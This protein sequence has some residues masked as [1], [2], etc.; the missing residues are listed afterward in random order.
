MQTNL[1]RPQKLFVSPIRYEIPAFQ[2][3]YVWQQEEQWE[4]LWADVIELAQSILEDGDAKPHFLGAVVLQQLPVPTGSIERRIVVDG[5]QR[6]TTLQLLIDAIQEV[7]EVQQFGGPAKRLLA[8]VENT[9]EFRDDNPDHAFKVWPTSVDRVPF[10]HTMSN[11]LSDEDFSTSRVVQ[12]HDFFLGQ[13]EQ[14]LDQFSAENGDRGEAASALERA[15][16]MHLEIVVIDLGESDDPHIIFETMNARGT[17]LLQSDMIKNKIL[18]DAKIELGFDD[19]KRSSKEIQLWP[20]SEDIWWTSEVGRGL[21]RRPRMDVFVNHWLTLRN[22]SETRQ[23]DEFSVFD[24]YANSQVESG[25]NIEAIARDIAS[26]GIS[27]RI[28]KNS[29]ETT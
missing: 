4:P 7:L 10:R 21:Q 15:V 5:Q 1:Q 25:G 16:R 28:S 13:T 26:S 8:L 17:P 2:R 19:T 29:A 18:H 12:A 9:D 20:F 27:T 22:L 14:W 24:R 23:F 11:D 6:L 3:R